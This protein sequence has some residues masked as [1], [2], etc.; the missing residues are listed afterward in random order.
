MLSHLMPCN[1]SASVYLA[2]ISIRASKRKSYWT[3]CE[4]IHALCTERQHEANVQGMCRLAM[5][6]TIN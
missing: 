6:E 2:R 4:M 3:G 5:N 1:S